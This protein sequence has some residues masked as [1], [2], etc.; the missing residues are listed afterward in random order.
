[1]RGDT[2]WKLFQQGEAK[3]VLSLGQLFN[4]IATVGANVKVDAVPNSTWNVVRHV[5][6]CL[7]KRELPLH[8]RIITSLAFNERNL[9]NHYC[10]RGGE[11]DKFVR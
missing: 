3:V 8:A 10:S 1:M 6:C 9:R 2:F 7:A 5:L 4:D 11:G